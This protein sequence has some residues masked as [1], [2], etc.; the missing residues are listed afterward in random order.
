MFY[1]L[2]GL[3]R[4]IEESDDAAERAGAKSEEDD[5][6]E[7]ERSAGGEIFLWDVGLILNCC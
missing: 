6:D 1:G 5:D 2:E 7:G 4:R 3:E